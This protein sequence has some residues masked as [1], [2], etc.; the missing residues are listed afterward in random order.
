MRLTDTLTCFYIQVFSLVR[1]GHVDVLQLRAPLHWRT[2]SGVCMSI[3]TPDFP[4]ILSEYV[5]T[6]ES[7]WQTAH[8]QEAHRNA[9][10]QTHSLWCLCPAGSTG[11]KL[12]YLSFWFT[13]Q[14]NSGTWYFKE[15]TENADKS[16]KM[17]KNTEK[18]MGEIFWVVISYK[19]VHRKSGYCQLEDPPKVSMS[20][21]SL[22]TLWAKL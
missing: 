12:F 7:A 4:L 8:K 16:V 18:G 14:R 11:T 21:G 3:S 2:E 20:W 22:S 10:E 6:T 15:N 9:S 1:D 19:K 13:V 5:F 17:W